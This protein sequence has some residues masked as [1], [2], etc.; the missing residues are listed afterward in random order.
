MAGSVVPPRTNRKRIFIGKYSKLHGK[1]DTN[2]REVI[3]VSVAIMIFVVTHANALAP[4]IVRSSIGFLFL[5]VAAVH[6][7]GE[8]DADRQ[9]KAGVTARLMWEMEFESLCYELMDDA[10]AAERR[11]CR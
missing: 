1:L 6:C 7:R 4:S 8:D 5:E 2:T 10:G 3:Q 9:Y 11:S